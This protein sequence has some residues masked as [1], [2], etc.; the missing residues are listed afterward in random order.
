MRSFS[1]SWSRPR[2]SVSLKLGRSG[3]ARRKDVALVLEKLLS[4][5][6]KNMMCKGVLL[7]SGF[8]DDEVSELEECEESLVEESL[9]MADTGITSQQTNERKSADTT[10]SAS[11]NWVSRPPLSMN[12]NPS[13]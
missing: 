1:L 5:D 8:E 3:R 12:F 2:R 6:P 7:P 11:F 9:E 10:F 4:E 13:S